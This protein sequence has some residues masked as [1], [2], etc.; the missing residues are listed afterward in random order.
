MPTQTSL[1]ENRY[2]IIP[3]YATILTSSLSIIYDANAY[4]Y[5]IHMSQIT[6]LKRRNEVSACCATKC[7]FDMRELQIIS[8]SCKPRA[9]LEQI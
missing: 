5:I 7:A 9:P 8:D 1:Q 4:A 6:L 3:S 2:T